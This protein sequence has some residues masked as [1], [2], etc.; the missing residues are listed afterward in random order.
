MPDL[1][2]VLLIDDNP[3][4][5]ML[6][7]RE[8]RKLFVIDVEEIIDNHDFNAALSRLDFDIVITD[9]QLRWTTGIEILIKIRSVKA[10]LPVIMF[11]GTGSEEVAVMAMKIGLDDYILK[12]PQHYNRLAM[13]VKGAIGRM[14]DEAR[15]KQAENALRQS[16][17]NYRS[18]VE[19]IELG[20]AR[21]DAAF[22]LIMVNST[23][24]KMF[25]YSKNEMVGLKFSDLYEPT[26]SILGTDEKDY[27]PALSMPSELFTRGIR[28]D[29]STF[30][31]HLRS[32]PTHN[33]SGSISGFI[34]I[35]EDISGRIRSE[36]LQQVV[37][38]IT[39][40]VMLTNDLVELLQNI[41][42]ELSKVIDTTNFRVILKDN[43]TGVLQIPFLIDEFE[44][45]SP[46]LA[47]RSLTGLVIESEQAILKSNMEI[48]SL[49][50]QGVINA[51]D[52]RIQQYLGVPL[53]SGK[54]V[55]GALVLIS[56]KQK[57]VFTDSDLD[58][59]Q[60]VS[61][62]IGLAIDN[63]RKEDELRENELKFRS[64]IEQSADGV[65]IVDSNGVVIEWNSAAYNI[66]GVSPEIAKGRQVWEIQF[67]LAEIE[68]KKESLRRYL[69]HMFFNTFNNFM[70]NKIVVVEEY[71]VSIDE[72]RKVLQVTA[73]P[74]YI[75]NLL[76]V[77]A[78]IKDFTL[79]NA[80][81]E[82][83][84]QAKIKA[85]ESDKL[86][87]AFLSNISHEVRTPLNAIVG[88]AA[89]ISESGLSEEMR[90]A[91][92]GQIFENSR[93]LLYQF[94][95]I[96]EISKIE[97]GSVELVN[98][99]FEVKEF[100]DS[101]IRQLSG[102]ISTSKIEFKLNKPL[103]PEEFYITA[104]RQRIR[105]VINQLLTN[106]FKFTT[107]G[108]VELGYDL[109]IEGKIRFYVKDTGPGIPEDMV[110][111]AFERFRQLDDSVD[112]KYTGMGVGL[113]IVKK[114]VNLLNG[115]VTYELLQPHGS[116]F[117]VILPVI[118]QNTKAMDNQ[119]IDNI[120]STTGKWVDKTIL[121]VEDVES[122]FQFLAATLRRSGAEL[123]W[124]KTGEDAIEIVRNN[125]NIDLVLMDVQLSGIDGYEV[126]RQIKLI[127]PA[128][129]VVA[130]TAYAMMGEKEKSQHAGCDAYLAKP[131]RP[132]LLISTISQY[133]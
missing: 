41:R 98:Y 113:N 133:L 35:V 112:R 24:A 118:F 96:I 80:S 104:D 48:K 105:Q 110:E 52:N 128:L 53:K 22:N 7:I 90:N 42:V 70:M 30:E 93:N 3:D 91:Y 83:I 102:L 100:L 13:S 12:S 26:L 84:A 131:I 34:H 51:F 97:S 81:A 92:S 111:M 6:I 19:N 16:E 72:Q 38:N 11:T 126:T 130:Q 82:A 27:N 77:G 61:N 40:A 54:S 75:N 23:Q 108:F 123:L 103:Y 76:H 2:K 88:F 85:E 116:L 21:V 57:D 46:L 99:E 89:L 109:S 15:R 69:K 50:N 1:L 124:S 119:I 59:M 120:A 64:F 106:A 4:D 68:G 114:I 115:E 94:N 37:Y 25:G 31:A 74:I 67:E 32:Y 122:N 29:G 132:S 66:S 44:N 121:I 125:H 86:K 5:R 49:L 63:K 65:I 56:Y 127:R 20:F 79:Q 60:F 117:S 71:D 95:N 58:I 28:S 10:L 43:R 47:D 87:T 55:I 45:M 36:R 14:A 18:L 8:L 17:E 73:F 129:P 62:Q 107:E 101:F 78:F 33:E 39:N 9:Y